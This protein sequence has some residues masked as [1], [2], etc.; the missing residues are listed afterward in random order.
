MT[1]KD[2][3]LDPATHD[4]LIEDFDLVLVEEADRV[5]QQIAIRLQMFK[6]EWFLDLDFGFPWFQ[7]VLGIKPPPLARTEALLR[8]Q[9]LGVPDVQELEELRL[10][11]VGAGRTLTVNLRVKTTFGSVAAE[12]TIP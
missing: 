5:R 2:F 8:E 11:Y 12:V 1:T 3:A 4:L 10:N 7:E 9:V 6:G